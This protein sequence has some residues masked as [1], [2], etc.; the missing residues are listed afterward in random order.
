[1]RD[2]HIPHGFYVVDSGMCTLQGFGNTAHRAV[3]DPE[4]VVVGLQLRFLWFHGLFLLECAMNI[5]ILRQ[6]LPFTFRVAAA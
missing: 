6:I 5:S 1:M 3:H 4:A 2:Q